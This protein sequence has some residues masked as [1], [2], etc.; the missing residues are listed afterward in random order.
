MKVRALQEFNGVGG[1][2]HAGNLAVIG[3]ALAREYAE[4]GLVEILDDA[5][6]VSIVEAVGD[7]AEAKLPEKPKKVRM[8]KAKA[9]TLEPNETDET[10]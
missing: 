1:R 10:K 5:K 7:E 3:E 4:A 6:P 9:E 2:W 8:K